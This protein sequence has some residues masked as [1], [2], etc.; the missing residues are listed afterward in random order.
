M[1]YYG[2]ERRVFLE[3]GSSIKLAGLNQQNQIKLI[4][5]FS[6]CTK[7]S[8]MIILYRVPFRKKSWR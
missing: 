2:I 1:E 8:L 5:N 7:L 6:F 3:D 4:G